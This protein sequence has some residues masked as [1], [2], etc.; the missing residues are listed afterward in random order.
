MNAIART[1]DGYLWVGTFGGLARFDGLR[2]NVVDRVDH[3]GRHLD[4]VLSLAVAPDSSLWVGTE[5]GLLQYRAGR[6]R[7]FGAADGLPD[8]QITALY[9]DHS[10]ALWVGTEHGGAAR[11]DGRRFL[12]VHEA[13]GVPFSTVGSF[14]EDRAGTMWI[15]ARGHYLTWNA[16]TPKTAEPGRLSRYGFDI[17]SLEDSD[18]T[19]WFRRP[20]GVGRVRHDQVELFRPGFGPEVMIAQQQPGRYWWGTFSHGVVEFDEDGAGSTHAY[21]LADG[22]TN[23][24]SRA[25][26]D[27]RDG[28]VWAGTTSNGLLRLKRN[29]FTTYR[30][31]NG[32]SHDIVTAVMEAR[33][34]ALWAGTNCGGVNT[35]DARANPF[36]PT[37]WGDRVL[38]GSLCLLARSGQRGRGVGR[39][40][41]RWPNG[42]IADGHATRVGGLG[43][44]R[45][46]VILAL[47]TDRSGTLWVG[48]NAAGLARFVG[49]KVHRV[50]TTADGLASN[51]VRTIAQTRDGAIRVG[52]LEGLSRLDAEGHLTSY[53]AADGLT[54]GYVRALYEDVDG[55]LW[56]GTYGGGLNRL[57]GGKFSHVTVAD[58]LPDNVVSSIL[59]DGRGNLWVEWQPCGISRVAKEQLNRL[60]DGE[61]RHVHTV[62]YGAGDGL[63]K[64][65]N[66][67]WL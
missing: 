31:A 25:L 61:L 6:F 46:S 55:T 57:R 41:W 35:I 28:N 33:D 14:V 11:Y 42:R 51:S 43:V 7:E 65:G 9:F 19:K 3:A 56:V 8:R 22:T 66:Q 44:L 59:D 12:P 62:L 40:L 54:S 17:L 27:G 45:D 18:G 1:P 5:T 29:L 38:E 39:H 36:A 32:L 67:R 50:Y 49:G 34:G 52:T 4:R 24:W 37:L 16:S 60:A 47:F 20:E 15:N 48:T 63:V 64:R 53:R 26:L 13:D 10:G 58:G 2:F 23:Y 21:P 30:T